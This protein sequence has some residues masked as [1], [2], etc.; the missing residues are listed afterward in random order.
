[1]LETQARHREAIETY[2]GVGAD[3]PFSWPAR[4]RIA[5]SYQSL[6]EVDAAEQLLRGMAAER[7]ERHDALLHLGQLLRAEERFAEAV[8]AYDE[9]MGRLG[10]VQPR[11]WSLFYF[12][13]ISL[14]R[15][16]Q[17]ARA[18]ADF[19]KALE[20][21]PE[22]PYVLNYL[23]YS[24]VDRGENLVKGREML[25]RAV[26]LRPEDGFIVDSLGWVYYRLGRYEE[27]VQQLERA[28]ELRPQDPVINDHLGDAYWRADRRREARFQWRHALALGAEPDLVAV[29]DRKLADGLLDGAGERAGD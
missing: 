17:W 1:V 7:P 29:I 11:H 22:E 26:E 21:Q 9:A 28:V 18:E 25:L 20:L 5:S 27:A 23:G 15:S 12:R 13:G 16:D 10:E 8:E 3:T 24:W 19:L 14:E 4:L 2:R 6:D